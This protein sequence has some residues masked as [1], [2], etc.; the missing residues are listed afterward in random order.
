M[1]L[2]L[3]FLSISIYVHLLSSSATILLR[4]PASSRWPFCSFILDG[5]PPDNHSYWHGYYALLL[6]AHLNSPRGGIF[7]KFLVATLH[8]AVSKLP[9]DPPTWLCDPVLHR[10]GEGTVEVVDC[11]ELPDLDCAKQSDPVGT[12]FA[13]LLSFQNAC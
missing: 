9:S 3:F 13:D 6:H 2:L 8:S 5:R 7:L 10:P 4:S 11:P 1:D 12:S